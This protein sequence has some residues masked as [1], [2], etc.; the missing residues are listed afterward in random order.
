MKL[1]ERNFKQGPISAEQESTKETDVDRSLV[2]VERSWTI[3]EYHVHLHTALP[4]NFHYRTRHCTI[5]H[6]RR[7]E[8]CAIDADVH[9]PFAELYPQD[10]QVSSSLS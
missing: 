8:E 10:M 7:I 5:R 6:K 4:Q 2:E 1:S 3:D 9:K